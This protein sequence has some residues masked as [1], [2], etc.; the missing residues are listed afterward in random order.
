M[1]PF[2]KLRVNGRPVRGRERRNGPEGVYSHL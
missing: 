1:L 2:D